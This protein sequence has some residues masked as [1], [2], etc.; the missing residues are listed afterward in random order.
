M[1]PGQKKSL[2]KFG[3]AIAAAD[4]SR[5]AE[6]I[7]D[8]GGRHRLDGLDYAAHYMVLDAVNDLWSECGRAEGYA[9]PLDWLA[10]E[11]ASVIEQHRGVAALIRSQKGFRP[12]GDGEPSR[13]T[14]FSATVADF[15]RI[16]TGPKIIPE[17]CQ[18]AQ[19]AQSP[20]LS[21]SRPAP[22]RPDE[23]TRA[24]RPVRPRSP[25]RRTRD[26]LRDHLGVYL[27]EHHPNK[28]LPTQS[29]I[30]E[31]AGRDEKTI[32]NWEAGRGDRTAAASYRMAVRKLIQIWI[33]EDEL[34]EPLPQ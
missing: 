31:Q 17:E 34:L 15:C 13:S 10:E 2:E 1:T 19:A 12:G 4:P 3:K 29:A 16:L 6:L 9:S 11:M 26:R 28:K 14:Q 23:G 5:T 33:P 22:L 7:R 8:K 30:A 20:A 18:L 32:R 24:E 25:R 27:L 21:E